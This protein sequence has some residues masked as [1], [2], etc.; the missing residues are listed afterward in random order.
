MSINEYDTRLDSNGYAPSL[1]RTECCFW[2]KRASCDIVRHEIYHGPN[3]NLSKRYGL[4][5]NLCTDCH[6]LVHNSDGKM[7]AILKDIGER[8][9]IKYY[10][11]TKD[12]FITIFGKNYI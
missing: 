8:A 4:W 12:R 1:L 11:W 9:A 3:R 6:Y 10:G 5:V 2:C 7:D